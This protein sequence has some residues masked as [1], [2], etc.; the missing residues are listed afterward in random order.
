MSKFL[1]LVMSLVI[2]LGPASYTSAQY[3]PDLPEH[4]TTVINGER[5]EAFAMEPFLELLRRDVE[6]QQCRVDLPA[7]AEQVRLLQASVGSLQGI[8]VLRDESLGLVTA[9]RD[10]YYSSYLEENRLRL[11]AENRPAIGSWLAWGLAAV[12][13]VATVALAITVAAISGE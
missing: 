11:E 7:T 8:V 3:R 12:F 6:V 1:A 5:Y 13:A 2:A 10:R 9:E 4:V